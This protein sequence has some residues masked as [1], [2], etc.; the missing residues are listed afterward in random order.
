MRV[1]LTIFVLSSFLLWSSTLVATHHAKYSN[2]HEIKIAAKFIGK[3][4]VSDQYFFWKK[5]TCQGPAV[6]I[7]F[8]LAKV[9][10]WHDQVKVVSFFTQKSVKYY[11]L[12]RVLRN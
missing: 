10:T 2:D 9:H 8:A 7:N 5:S 11:L 1:K 4:T 6:L 3:T 12:F